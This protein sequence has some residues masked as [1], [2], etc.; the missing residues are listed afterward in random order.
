MSTPEPIRIQK[1]LADAGVCSRRAAEALVAQ[2]EVWI[3][4]I[5]AVAGRKVIPGEDRIT[6][7]GKAVRAGSQ[8]RITLAVHKPRGLVCS[9]D[10]PHN[11]E[12]VFSLLP[13]QYARYRFFCAGRLDK[14]S[15]GLVI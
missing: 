15:E 13:P 10:D 11:P 5:P 1:Y 3:N 6:V 7:S 12:T 4:G 14:D 2:G 9:N 8:P